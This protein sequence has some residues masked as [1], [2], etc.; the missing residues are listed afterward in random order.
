MRTSFINDVFFAEIEKESQ[1]RLKVDAHWNSELA[2][3][4]DA[5]GVVKEGKVADM[6]IVVPEYTPKEFL[7]QQIFKSFPIGPTGA[8]QV[9]FFRKAYDTIPALQ[10]EVARQN[11]VNLFLATGYPVAFFSTKPLSKLDDITGQS[12]VQPASGIRIS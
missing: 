9:E 1:G 4:Y 6:A 7:L 10:A 5:L 2:R 3:S 12:G 8:K 11:G